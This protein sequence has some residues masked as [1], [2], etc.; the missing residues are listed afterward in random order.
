MHH[1]EHE[2]HYADLSTDRFQHFANICGSNALLQRE[3]NVTDVDKVKANEKEV[4]DRV[5]QSFVAAEG[6]D[7]KNASVFMQRLC[8]P[9]GE[10][11]AQRDVNNVSPNYRSN[12]IFLSLVSVSIGR[13]FWFQKLQRP[14]N[15]LALL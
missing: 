12:G 3:R 2:H 9:D 1:A 10:R 8:C 7:Q 11:N 5:G 4:I 6:V 14:G 15:H 13:L